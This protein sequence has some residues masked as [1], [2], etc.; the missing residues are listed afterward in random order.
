MLCFEAGILPTVLPDTQHANAQAAT[1]PH[2]LH[3]INITQG[4]SLN[5]QTSLH[6]TM[7]QPFG[8]ANGRISCSGG[9]SLNQ[10]SN[11]HTG[12][13]F[14]DDAHAYHVG[15]PLPLPRLETGACLAQTPFFVSI[16]QR[17]VHTKR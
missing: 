5:L 16:R 17:F 7:E 14:C 4:S 1:R 6:Q 2:P 3:P 8:F 15:R 9:E 13:L 11:S 12:G 10:G